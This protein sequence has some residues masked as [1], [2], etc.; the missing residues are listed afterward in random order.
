MRVRIALFV[1]IALV[2]TGFTGARYAGLVPG[3]EYPVH[4]RLARTGGLFAGGE[5]THRGV[6]VGRVDRVRLVDGVVQADLLIDG[7]VAIP[8][9]ARAVVTNRSAVG[10]QYLDFKPG[11]G[12]GSGDLAGDLAVGEVVPIGRTALPP[13]VEGVLTELD[14]L[15]RSVPQD[16]LR[17]VVDELDLALRDT[18][19]DLGLL[20]DSVRDLTA[21]AGEHLPRTSALLRDAGIV[22]DTQ[23]DQAAAITSFAGS[24]A[25]VAAALERGDADLRRVIEAGPGVGEEVGGLLRESG[26]G[27]GATLANLVT[28][29][30]VLLRRQGE[31]EQVL[32]SLPRAVE[33][34]QSVYSGGGVS[35]GLALTFFEP[36]PCTQ[37]YEATARRG[38]LDTGP[39]AFNAGAACTL[40]R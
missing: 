8:R 38:A 33:V 18:G 23:L 24:A 3:D 19:P 28:T 37:G 22:L 35:L 14:D 20:L 9:A 15:A 34:G 1:V 4:V 17:T 2:G 21:T 5:V 40:P 30:D 31:L 36:P 11:D 7:G 39:A 16:A 27:L 10:E 32:V 6:R 25:Q 29:A 12:E 26:G 13:P